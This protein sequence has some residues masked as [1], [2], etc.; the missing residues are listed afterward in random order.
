MRVRLGHDEEAAEG[1]DG[2]GPAVHRVPGA[3]VEAGDL[4]DGAGVD[5]QVTVGDA[6]GA[7]VVEQD[8]HAVGGEPDVHLERLGALVEGLLVG[9]V[10]EFGVVGGG[11]PV[12]DD[13]AAGGDG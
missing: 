13:A 6:G 12:G 3:H 8:G 7:R 10:G 9:D 2:F 4:V 1:H 5:P 11:A